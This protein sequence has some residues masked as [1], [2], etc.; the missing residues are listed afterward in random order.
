[1]N[2]TH[3]IITYSK[4]HYL[5]TDEQNNDLMEKTLDDILLVDGNAIKVR[6]I[7]E[8][9]T[10]SKYYES[11]PDKRPQRIDEFKNLDGMGFGGVIANSR[12][13]ALKGIIKGLKR[14]IESDKYQGTEAPKELLKVA[15][16]RLASIL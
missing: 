2:Q 13:T 1:M 7:A 10:I 6:N 3:A 11:Y 8:V 9:M 12:E 5:I 16:Q 4:T 14:Y 15:E